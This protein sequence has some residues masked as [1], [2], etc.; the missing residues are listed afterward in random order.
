MQISR[1]QVTA[2]TQY[3]SDGIPF[4]SSG[5]PQSWLQLQRFFLDEKSYSTDEFIDP[6]LK[7]FQGPA[8]LAY[9][10]AIFTNTNFES[11]SG[12][13]DSLKIS[14]SLTA[15]KFRRSFNLVGIDLI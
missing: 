15:G 4:I 11:L 14:D 5:H 12:L 8:L 10:S 9:N 2:N 1:R 6:C 3:N 13:R 7:Q